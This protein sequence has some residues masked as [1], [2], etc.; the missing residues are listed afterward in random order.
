MTNDY[1]YQL[2]TGADINFISWAGATVCFVKRGWCDKT[3]TEPI[4][5]TD[6]C[7]R[8]SAYFVKCYMKIAETHVKGRSKILICINVELTAFTASLTQLVTRD[9][10]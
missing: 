7:G 9:E 3:A 8:L 4:Y 2:L 5:C 1:I 10:W 6:L